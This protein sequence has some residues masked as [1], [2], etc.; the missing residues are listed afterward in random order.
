MND[1][2]MMKKLSEIQKN[3]L[4]T[5]FK[6]VLGLIKITNSDLSYMRSVLIRELKPIYSNFF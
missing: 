5:K 1:D 2:E 6:R 4:G 3:S